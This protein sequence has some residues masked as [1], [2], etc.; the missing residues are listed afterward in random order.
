MRSAQ[1]YL[2]QLPYCLK[3]SLVTQPTNTNGRNAIVYCCTLIEMCAAMLLLSTVNL[4]EQYIP[5][6]FV[7]VLDLDLDS[8]LDCDLDPDLCRS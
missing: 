1:Y 8:D 4:E 2:P 5:P 3:G 6:M 7:F